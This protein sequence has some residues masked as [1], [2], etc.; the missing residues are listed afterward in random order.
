M[1]R[2]WISLGKIIAKGS[3]FIATTHILKLG[4]SWTLKAI[5]DEILLSATS[6]S[7]FFFTSTVEVTLKILFFEW[8]SQAPGNYTKSDEVMVSFFHDFLW[9]LEN[10]YKRKISVFIPLS[11][12]ILRKQLTDTIF[13]HSF[14]L[15][16][17]THLLKKWRSLEKL[18]F[19]QCPSV[20]LF[21]PFKTILET[22][23]RV[24]LLLSNSSSSW[25]SQ[26]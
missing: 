6:F 15:K 25:F 23:Y 10:I 16:I 21:F 1:F 24:T 18:S 3:A 4:L 9:S 13:F 12:D 7:I 8:N 26:S 5:K 2:N 14:S 20:W 11:N 17:L 22:Q 19:F